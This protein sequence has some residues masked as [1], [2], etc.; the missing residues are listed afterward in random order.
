MVDT[1]NTGKIP[2]NE[3]EKLLRQSFDLTVKGIIES[4]A[5]MKPCF[6][7]LPPTGTL[8]GKTRTLVGRS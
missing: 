8:A 4:L 5:L 7:P 2:D 3:L 6:Y 1:F